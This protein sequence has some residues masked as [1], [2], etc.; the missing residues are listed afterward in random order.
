MDIKKERIIIKEYYS[1]EH[2]I[3]EIAEMVGTVEQ[4]IHNWIRAQKK[5][6]IIKNVK[7]VDLKP[8][9]VEIA[10]QKLNERSEI[11]IS[12]EGVNCTSK[13]AKTCRFGSR[14]EVSN[15][16]CNFMACTG[17][18]RIMISPDPKDCH[19]YQ[20]ITKENPRIEGRF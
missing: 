12:A 19:C 16:L 7:R 14:A 5:R 20:K 9:E 1:Q 13:V 6:G 8:E 3:P 15:Y 10:L 11:I 4:N 18:S 2:T 17:R